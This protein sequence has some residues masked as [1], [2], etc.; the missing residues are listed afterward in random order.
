MEGT[1]KKAHDAIHRAEEETA[2]KHEKS[3][4]IKRLTLQM[5]AVTSEI[6]KNRWAEGADHQALMNGWIDDV[7]CYAM[8]KGD[9]HIDDDEDDVVV[10]VNALI[11]RFDW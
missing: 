1:G 5:Q 8:M 9:N 6:S 10:V 2:R 11:D 3:G 7:V 4:D